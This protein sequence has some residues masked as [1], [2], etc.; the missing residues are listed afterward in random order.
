MI[1]IRQQ[2]LVWAHIRQWMPDAKVI[3]TYLFM[4]WLIYRSS[5]SAN[6]TVLHSWCC[7]AVQSVKS[8]SSNHLLFFH[9]ATFCL[10]FL[11][12]LLTY[13][14]CWAVIIWLQ[15]VHH[16]QLKQAKNMCCVAGSAALLEQW[17]V[18]TPAGRCWLDDCSVPAWLEW[19]HFGRWDGF[20]KKGEA[21][22]ASQ[23]VKVWTNLHQYKF[24]RWWYSWLLP[25]TWWW[26]WLCQLL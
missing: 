23:K 19:Q 1:V 8:L 20:G 7:T 6:L 15:L 16:H 2:E 3:S 5:A 26:F 22:R 13:K 12:V 21:C 14:R 10:S 4:R 24:C 9:F 11:V 18:Q 25:R 17:T